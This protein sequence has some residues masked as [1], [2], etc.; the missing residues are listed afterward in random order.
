MV[1]ALLSFLA[2]NAREPYA[3]GTG[4]GFHLEQRCPQADGKARED[5]Q[6]LEVPLL[7]VPKPSLQGKMAG[8]KP[9]EGV[10]PYR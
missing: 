6:V 1:T 5:E 10:S 9:D 8:R 4:S 7:I 3:D 2:L